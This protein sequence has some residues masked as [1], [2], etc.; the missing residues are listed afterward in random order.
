MKVRYKIPVIEFEEGEIELTKEGEY[1]FKKGWH[2]EALTEIGCD[3]HLFM[4]D[5]IDS[6]LEIGY[7]YIEEIK[8]VTLDDVRNID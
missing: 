2:K 8:D 1:Y 7:A 3:L 4:S 6:A 5:H